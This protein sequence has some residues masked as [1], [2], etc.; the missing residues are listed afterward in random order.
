VLDRTARTCNVLQYGVVRCEEW[1][2]R[3]GGEERR[4]GRDEG[5]RKEVSEAEKR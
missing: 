4:G 2:Q 1:K 5:K 3:R